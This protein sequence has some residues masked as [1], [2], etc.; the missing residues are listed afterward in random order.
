MYQ[1]R[2]SA[3]YEEA[4]SRNI[5][6]G[7]ITFFL[8]GIFTL[9]SIQ[10]NSVVLIF[11]ALMYRPFCPRSYRDKVFGAFDPY[12]KF[13]PSPPPTSEEIHNASIAVAE[14]IGGD[15]DVDGVAKGATG[16]G[17]GGKGANNGSARPSS[18][19][20]DRSAA[21]SAYVVK[22]MLDYRNAGWISPLSQTY[23]PAVVTAL[24]RR[25]EAGAGAGADG[26]AGAGAE[27]S[28]PAVGGRDD[29]VEFSTSSSSVAVYAAKTK[30]RKAYSN[31]ST[32]T[33][34]RD[35]DS[36][37]D[38]VDADPRGSY[39]A[40]PSRPVLPASSSAALSFNVDALTAEDDNVPPSSFTTKSPAEKPPCNTAEWNLASPPPCGPS[41][42]SSSVPGASKAS[43]NEGSW[44]RG[45]PDW[46]R[47]L[48]ELRVVTEVN[49]K[50]SLTVRRLSSP[51]HTVSCLYGL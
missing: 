42:A 44:R 45:L 6:I 31:K 35:G 38:D 27:A 34:L 32:S 39:S 16:G 48:A 4:L 21:M 17:R 24:Y 9:Y 10:N 40:T 41:S 26:A 43:R 8:L 20:E 37:G 18:Y 28:A 36:I 19:Y 23:T 33:L 25:D 49:F 12:G 30:G 11:G 7:I 50:A 29:L 5:T 13:R 46:K 51:F 22:T 14:A 3:A 1:R 47:Q 15:V 2:R